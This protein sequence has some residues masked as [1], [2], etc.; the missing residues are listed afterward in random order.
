[1]VS[2]PNLGDTSPSTPNHTKT[3]MSSHVRKY[4]KTQ[5]VNT[6]TKGFTS[7]R[8]REWTLLSCK[9]S[10]FHTK[11]FWSITNATWI[12]NRQDMKLDC[13]KLNEEESSIVSFLDTCSS[14]VSQEEL[15]WVER[16]LDKYRHPDHNPTT[17]SFAR[18]HPRL[19]YHYEGRKCSEVECKPWF[20]LYWVERV[21]CR[22]KRTTSVLG[23]ITKPPHTEYDTT[24]D[25]KTSVLCDEREERR[26]TRK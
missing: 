19:F 16:H 26:E 17:C 20:K 21:R 8:Y 5:V 6:Q 10:P 25:M 14:G 18:H 4:T 9:F 3:Q 13:W 24:F 1:M 7:A 12:K 15:D 22:A 23:I 2:F 11:W